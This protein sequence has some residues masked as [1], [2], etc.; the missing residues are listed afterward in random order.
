MDSIIESMSKVS[1]KDQAVAFKAVQALWFECYGLLNPARRDERA[2][3]ARVLAVELNA[4]ITIPPSEE[5]KKKRKNKNKEL[6][7]EIKPKH[8]VSTR[9]VILRAL[10]FVGGEAEVPEIARTFGDLDLREMAR[11]ALDRNPSPAATAAL[12]AA[13][14]DCGPEF[15]IG[16]INS[17]ARKGG[18]VALDAIRKLADDPDPEIRLVAIEAMSRFPDPAND[19][20]MAQAGRIGSERARSRVAKARLRLAENLKD[21]GHKTA[22]KRIYQ[23]IPRDAVAQR[24]AAEAA[25]KSME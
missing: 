18:P 1:D 12:V 24:R 20:I 22:A 17:L 6:K 23:S 21:H 19:A 2:A 15:R 14:D 5:E 11:Y 4:T 16:V 13:L 9:S 25:L 10:S 7:P 8:D 3:F